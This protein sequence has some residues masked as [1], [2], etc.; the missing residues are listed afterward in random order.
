MDFS[1][2]IEYAKKSMEKVM[3]HR[4][5]KLSTLLNASETQLDD[6]N[7]ITMQSENVINE[8]SDNSCSST[9]KVEPSSMPKSP[10]FKVN[11][12]IKERTITLKIH[13]RIHSKQKR[14]TCDQCQKTFTQKH[15]L[16]T[17]KMVHTGEKPYQCDLCCM[18]FTR[19][20]ILTIHKR[21]HTG[22]KPY[23]CDL[24]PKKFAQSNS[25]TYH[26]RIHTGIR[27]YSCNQCEKSFFQLNALKI[28]LNTHINSR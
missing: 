11:S 26:K 15:N 16:L 1:S 17:H 27:P 2:N 21:I 7:E 24:C 25:L 18:K 9:I 20:D 23:S 3:N 12:S 10:R 13:N 8:T 14:F 22:D 5:E 19:S 6:V 4:I 28:H